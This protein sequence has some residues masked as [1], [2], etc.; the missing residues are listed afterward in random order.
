M[1]MLKPLTGETMLLYLQ[2]RTK[3]LAVPAGHS[4]LVELL[5]VLWLLR[6]ES[7]DHS[8]NNN[9]FHAPLKMALAMEDNS[10]KL[11]S[12]LR[13]ILFNLKETINMFQAMEKFQ[14]AHMIKLK[15]LLKFKDTS[16]YQL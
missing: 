16:L 4:Q 7:S 8:L 3:P 11:L 12:I 10:K 9:L 1:L 14:L 2:L 5:K 13:Q 15:A 6:P